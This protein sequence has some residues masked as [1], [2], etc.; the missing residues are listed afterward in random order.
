MKMIQQGTDLNVP[1][2]VGRRTSTEGYLFP[3]Q[4]NPGQTVGW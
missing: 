2:I 1:S 3:S 4:E